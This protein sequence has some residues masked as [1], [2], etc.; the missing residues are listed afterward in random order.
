MFK[1]YFDDIHCRHIV[2]GGSADNGYARMLEPYLQSE[3]DRGRI[4]LLEGPPFAPELVRIKNRFRTLSFPD[5]LRDDKLPAV[6]IVPYVAP[7]QTI[8]AASTPSS[9]WAAAASKPPITPPMDHPR[10]LSPKKE[11]GVCRNALGQRVD[12][13]LQYN[14]QDFFDI[15]PLKLC[16]NYHLLGSCYQGKSCSHKHGEKLGPRKLAALRALSR[17]AA[18]PWGLDCDDPDCI[19]GHR[20]VRPNCKRGICQ[21]SEEMHDVDT[22]IVTR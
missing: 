8:P 2:F 20:C 6:R 19:G 5:I 9:G 7:M 3:T 16:N 18:C 14:Q 22:K 15:R 10:A 12:S 11:E 1:L 13:R 21:F 17:S 4:T